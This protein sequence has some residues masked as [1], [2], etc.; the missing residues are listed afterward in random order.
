LKKYL[1]DYFRIYSERRSLTVQE[2]EKIFDTVFQKTTENEKISG[3]QFFLSP[4]RIAAALGMCL[5]LSISAIWLYGRERV[6][7]DEENFGEYFPRGN[8]TRPLFTVFCADAKQAGICRRSDIL[9]FKI[10]PPRNYRYFSSFTRHIESNAVVWY[11]PATEDGRSLFVQDSVTGEGE[12]LREGIVIGNDHALGEHEV[13]GIFSARALSWDDI[14][15]L[16]DDK[17]VPLLRGK[18]DGTD[19]VFR[20]HG[21]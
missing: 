3:W 17:G 5:L 15:S 2:H 4:I 7:T 1:Q 13:W 6:T 20:L 16:F 18:P 14:R 12:L 21:I 11:Y 8:D 9:V 10:R 19:S